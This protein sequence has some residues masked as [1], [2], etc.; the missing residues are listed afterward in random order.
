MISHDDDGDELLV[1][2]LDVTMNDDVEGVWPETNRCR[3]Y[4][5]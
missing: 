2:K 3:E 1:G 4:R 5:R